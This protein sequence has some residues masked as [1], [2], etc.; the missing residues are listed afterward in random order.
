M[1]DTA[2]MTNP[3]REGMRIRKTPAPCAMVI[4]GA[5]GDLTA[6][7][8]IPA[9]YYLHCERLL[10]PGFSVIGCAKTPYSNEKF[11]EAM[12]DAVKKFSEKATVDEPSLTS[13]IQSLYYLTDDFGDAKAYTQLDEL[14]NKLDSERGTNGNRLFY[15]ATPPSSFPVI[16]NHLGAAGLAQPKDPGKSWTRVVIEKPF[17]HDLE[18]ARE[19]TATVGSVFK[20]EQ[21]YRIDHY[22][23]KETVQNLLVFRFANGI[24]EP[25][26]NRR[27]IDH[28][29]ITVAEELGVEGR[30]RYYEEAGLLRDMVQNHVMSV[31][32]LVAMESPAT[33]DA[34]EV[35]DEKAKVMRAI[36]PIDFDHLDDFVVRG[37]YAE[38]WVK[39]QKVPGYCE[40]ANVASNSS[41]ET[42]AALKLSIDN[43]RWADV[44]FYLRSGKRL[45]KRVSEIVV[46]FRRVPHMV[47]GS[48]TENPVEPNV[49][50]MRI[51]PNE[52]I[53]INFNA[54]FPAP[55]MEI[56]PVKMEF[57]YSESFGGEPPSAYE[58]LLLD[59][60]L[61]D[62]TLFTREDAVELAWQL[63]SP[64]LDRWREDGA[65]GLQYY[66]SGS[67]GPAAAD[68][69][70]ERDKRRWHRL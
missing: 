69:L 46:Q 27:Y 47:F 11:R 23:G 37:Q 65:K 8:L 32:S 54:K 34:V 18:S 39:G 20:E 2:V 45:A 56:R 22:L 38:G 24:F 55:T 50:A 21:V 15:L 67:W 51:Q 53:A 60:M 41:T 25:I 40:E 28:V 36:R 9:L 6:R 62:Q 35:R 66:E 30:G 49:L 64:L 42:F 52:G 48:K 17:G 12:A 3:L 44:P 1:T 63:L 13:F 59:C 14:L 19:L 57:R 31:L 29:E 33:F 68:A 26:W 7:K 5:S 16:V 70:L 4:F 58:T 43:W 61:G 10:P